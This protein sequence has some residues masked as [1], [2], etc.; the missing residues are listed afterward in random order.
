MSRA[1]ARGIAWPLALVLAAAPGARGA[2]PDEARAEAVQLTSEG[3]QAYMSE[4]YAEA[5]RKFIQAYEKFPA[6]AL[7]LN[8]SRVALKL[9]RCD[10]AIRYAQLYKAS[11]VEIRAVSPDSPD[12]WF[13]S[14]EQSC[15]ETE[16]VTAPPGAALW[17]DGIRQATPAQTPWTG[18]LTAG[19]HKVL[20]W[21]KGYRNQEA[22]LIVS[23]AQ[24]ARLALTLVH[25][26]AGEHEAEPTV[27]LDLTPHS[28]PGNSLSVVTRSGAHL[29][30]NIGWAGVA[31]G[32]AALLVG[33]ILGAT[34]SK[35]LA[36]A[37]ETTS[38][39][40][41]R[42]QADAQLNSIAARSTG[43]DALFGIGGVLAAGGTALV[44]VF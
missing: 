26:D 31:A 15:I 34:A 7:M 29:W 18:R 5:R 42:A 30:K 1:V 40:R 32:G 20:V 11:S 43:A 10:E 39:T 21:L 24:P 2:E 36:T 13:T 35:D 23:P 8:L 12:L 33:V 17:I 28:V 44:V 16:I 9:S 27:V 22:Q 38:P 3:A 6:P 14:V 25:A 41:T 19:T 4:N 37:H